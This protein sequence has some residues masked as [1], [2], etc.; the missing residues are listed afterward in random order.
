MPHVAIFDTAF[1]ATL[2]PES[3]TYAINAE[4]AREYYLNDAGNQFDL[5]AA[6]MLARATGGSLPEQG[7][8]GD[9]VRVTDTFEMIRPR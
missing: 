5:F 8:Q 3:Y 9:Y 7:Y 4:V 6:S 1:F 2:P